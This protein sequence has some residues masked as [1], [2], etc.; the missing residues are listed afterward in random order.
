MEFREPL[1]ALPL[2]RCFGGR[3]MKNKRAADCEGSDK[4]FDREISIFKIKESNGG[5]ETGS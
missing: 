1:K 4:G 2:K 3:L 5:R